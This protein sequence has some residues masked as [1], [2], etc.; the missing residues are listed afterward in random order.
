MEIKRTTE[1]F[2]ETKRRFI[3]RGTETG[4]LRIC[5]ACGETMLAAEQAAALL[6]INCR[7]IFQ[8]IE[9]GAT[10]FVENPTG[11]TLVC[12]TSLAAALSVESLSDRTVEEL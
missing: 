2:V 8:I 10:H 7:T 1:I 9:R 12:P 5:P 3:V 11:A 6:E 4:E